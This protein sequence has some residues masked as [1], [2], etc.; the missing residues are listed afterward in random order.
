M[1]V[2]RS[3]GGCVLSGPLAAPQ[4]VSEANCPAQDLEEPLQRGMLRRSESDGAGHLERSPHPTGKGPGK[5]ITAL[6]LQREVTVGHG[7]A[8][9]VTLRVGI[10]DK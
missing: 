10:S 1:L 9:F 5:T 3:E 6:S 8:V 7:G 4:S 2:R